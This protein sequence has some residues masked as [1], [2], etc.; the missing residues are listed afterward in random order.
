MTGR[1]QLFDLEAVDALDLE[2][3]LVGRSAAATTVVPPPIGHAGRAREKQSLL[4][5]VLLYQPVGNAYVLRR[6]KEVIADLPKVAVS[7]GVQLEHTFRGLSR[8]R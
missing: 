1:G 7:L 2:E 8:S 6:G 4:E 3:L 5:E